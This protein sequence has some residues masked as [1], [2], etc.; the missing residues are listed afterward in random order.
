MAFT[1]FNIYISNERE[2]KS[3]LKHSFY[4]LVLKEIEDANLL[5]E[6]PKE[7]KSFY[8]IIGYGYMYNTDDSYSIDRFLSPNEFVKINL[9]QDYYEYDPTLEYFNLSMYQN[10]LIFFEVVEGN[11]L[12]IDKK[13]INGK[14]II[15][16]F[17]E[18]IANSLEEFLDKFDKEGHYFE[19]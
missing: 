9:R 8:S 18:K 15:Y 12:L 6:I 1:D 10:K 16:Y 7:L 4:P 5:L 14:N 17:D 11:Y 19:K 13:D 2:K 3:G